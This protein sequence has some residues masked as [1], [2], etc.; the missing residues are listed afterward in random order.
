MKR[1]KRFFLGVMAGVCGMGLVPLCADSA[2]ADKRVA[3]VIGNAAYQNAAALPNPVNDATAI[4][5]MFRDV[6]FDVVQS[7]FDLGV[8]DLKRAIREF[9]LQARDADIAV[10][11]YAGHGIEIGGINYLVPVDARLATDVAAE[12]EAVPLDRVIRAVEPAHRLRLVILD[13]CRD[14]PFGS[15]MQRTVATRAVSS[16]LARIEP[17]LSDTMIAYA[18]KAGSTVADG[19]GANSPFTAALLKHL[20]EPGVD[21]RIA[22]GR[23]RDDVWAQTA[24]RQEPFVY[25]SFGGAEVPLVA[26]AQPAEPAPAAD[27]GAE[28]RRAYELTANVGTRAA[29]EAFLKGFAT[30]LYADLARAQLARLDAAEKPVS[31]PR[32][33]VAVREQPATEAVPAQADE[34]PARHKSGRSIAAHR[35]QPAETHHHEFASPRRHEAARWPRFQSWRPAPAFRGFAGPRC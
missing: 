15:R 5:K 20:P 32:T 23:V 21:V 13:A 12:D 22:F 27:G 26:A 3:L 8:L 17:T 10:V 29:W 19:S 2:L 25:G 30:G 1:I 6:G 7:R 14:N 18:A 33:D 35:H 9:T 24:H 16:G 4:G 34:E 31:N 11:Y 28:A